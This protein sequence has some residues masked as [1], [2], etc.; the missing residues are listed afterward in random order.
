MSQ[1]VH[2]KVR[3][4]NAQRKCQIPRI[5]SQTWRKP[6]PT[7][8]TMSA[9]LGFAKFLSPANHKTHGTIKSFGQMRP[10]CGPDFF[11]HNAVR[12][13]ENKSNFQ[14]LLIKRTPSY[15]MLFLK[16]CNLPTQSNILWLCFLI[17]QKPTNQVI[18]GPNLNIISIFMSICCLPTS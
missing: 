4:C 5:T 8:T 6:V 15:R 16:P 7:K 11:S 2:P 13:G 14:N 10:Q 3:S 12:F 1:Q 18:Q 17:S 9:W